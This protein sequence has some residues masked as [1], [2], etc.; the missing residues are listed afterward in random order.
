MS[1]SSPRMVPGSSAPPGPRPGPPPGPR[2]RRRG[3]GGSPAAGPTAR[4]RCGRRAA[5]LIQHLALRV[6]Q[7]GVELGGR[8]LRVE[9]GRGQHA[10]HQVGHHL[11]QH[12]VADVGRARRLEGELL[13]RGDLLGQE[14]RRVVLF[15]HAHQHAVTAARL[16]GLTVLR[17]LGRQSAL[18]GHA[19]VDEVAVVLRH[20]RAHAAAQRGRLRSGQAGLLQPAALL[21]QRLLEHVSERAV[22]VGVV[23]GVEGG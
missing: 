11:G 16:A 7:Q 23:G 21:H 4:R 12:P 10:A 5:L 3:G 22:V 20:A 15:G 6:A 2:Y 8:Q 14:A 19:L 1:A 17:I 9:V 13:Q 18:A